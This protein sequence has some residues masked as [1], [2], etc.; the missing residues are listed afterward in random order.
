[1]G[2]NINRI[3]PVE[4]AGTLDNKIRS[5]LQ[6]PTQVL[7]PY[8]KEGM[9]VLDIGCG[10]GFFSIDIAYMVGASGKVIAADLQEGMLN[11]LR[12]KISG[13]EIENRIIL[14][15]CEENKI[16]ISE[17]VDFVLAFYMV[18]EVTNKEGLFTEIETILK[19]SGQ[20][21]IVEPPIHVS[22]KTFEDTI[23]KAIAA[24]FKEVK[25]PKLLFNKAVLLKK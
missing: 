13:T 22:K 19:P 14:H 18:H 25:R 8:V 24:G 11:K 1:M 20:L 21:L 16:G 2:D 6:D 3:C 7:K 9:T 17:K 5:W 10:T 23:R 4:L 15:K 12:D